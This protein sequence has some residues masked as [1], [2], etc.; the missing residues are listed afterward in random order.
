MAMASLPVMK[1]EEMIKVSRED[2][3]KVFRN[4][5]GSDK[6]GAR[7]NGKRGGDADDLDEEEEDDEDEEMDTA[8]QLQD[9]SMEKDV[10]F[11]HMEQHPK[12]PR[13]S[14][15]SNQPGTDIGASAFAASST[16]AEYKS[17]PEAGSVSSGTRWCN[18]EPQVSKLQTQ[19]R[20][21]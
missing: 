5:S 12:V 19:V 6:Y 13:P 4:I 16:K 8:A 2:R 11:F 17:L 15:A 21:K 3:D 18:G 9:I 20:Y 14:P 10:T 1:R 7:A